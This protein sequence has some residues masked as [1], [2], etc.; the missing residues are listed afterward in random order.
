MKTI[1][2]IKKLLPLLAALVLM[3]SC[4]SEAWN[5]HYTTEVTEKSELT[6][7]EYIKSKPE[8]SKFAQA[9]EISGFDKVLSENITYTVW[10]PD[11]T[12]LANLDLTNVDMVGKVVRNHIT[13]FSHPTSRVEEQSMLMLNGKILEFKRQSGDKFTL[14]G[15]ELKQPNIAVRNGMIHLM[16]DYVPYI[17]N[18]WEYIAVAQ[19]IDSLRNYVNSLTREEFDFD[20]SYLDGVLV[21]SIFKVTNTVLTSLASLNRE[22]SM[23][24]ALLPTDAAWK[25]R[26]ELILPYYKTLDVDGGQRA[27]L[28]NARWNMVRDVFFRGRLKQPVVSDSIQSTVGT[29]FT[30][31]SQLI[32]AAAPVEVSNGYSYIVNSYQQKP[33][34]SFLQPIRVEAENTAYGRSVKD[35]E[36][37][38]FSSIGTGYDI[39]NRYYINARALSTNSTARMNINFPIPNTLASKYNIYCVF[40]PMSITD[41][42][43]ARKYKVRFSINYNYT[44]AAKSDSVWIG[45]NGFVKIHTQAKVFET[46]SKKITKVLVA[47]NY[48]FPWANL[49]GLNRF[50]NMM[51]AEKIRVGLR[52]ENAAGTTVLERLNYSRDLR[53]D[54]ILLEPVQ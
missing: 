43:N 40:V 44:D 26:L 10:V 39:S 27:Q 5:N 52:V 1:L 15:K 51:L 7:Y 9:L 32:P 12:A 24:T 33:T 45:N 53:I 16:S 4:E 19:G 49:Y 47:Q 13:R 14:H 8:L 46:E 20:A 3:V 30:N 18:H 21:D 2:S 42:T 36:I 28:T 25:E 48:E 17:F 35:Y 50:S 23:Y 22:D 11:N 29:Q 38:L 41:S 31:A 37:S 54:Y 34:E 6:I